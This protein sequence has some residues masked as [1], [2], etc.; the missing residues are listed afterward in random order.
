MTE[1]F[2]SLREIA[3]GERKVKLTYA[4][5][6]ALIYIMGNRLVETIKS[7]ADYSVLAGLKK[8]KKATGNYNAGT[9]KIIKKL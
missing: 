8:Q 2:E 9:L 3:R 4:G 6:W 5:K 7:N 1:H